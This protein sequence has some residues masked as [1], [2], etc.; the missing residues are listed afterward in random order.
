M[1]H[2]KN[3]HMQQL[4]FSMYQKERMCSV[5]K[6]TNHKLEKRGEE[7]IADANVPQEDILFILCTMK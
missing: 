1:W 7:V 5:Y 2:Q 3:K 4:N 6:L